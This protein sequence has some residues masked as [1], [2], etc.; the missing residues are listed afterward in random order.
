MPS[1]GKIR[2]AAMDVITQ[3]TSKA[4]GSEICGLL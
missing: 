3:A 2:N 4:G 1:T